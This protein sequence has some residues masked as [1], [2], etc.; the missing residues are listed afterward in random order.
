MK[1]GRVGIDGNNARGLILSVVIGKFR[2]LLDCVHYNNF[3][4]FCLELGS[5]GRQEEDHMLFDSLK[6]KYEMMKEEFK[7]GALENWKEKMKDFC[8]QIVTHSVITSEVVRLVA[9]CA[10]NLKFSDE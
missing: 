5:V 3:K 4:A 9:V 6:M 10:V 7:Q 1:L 2:N 8:K